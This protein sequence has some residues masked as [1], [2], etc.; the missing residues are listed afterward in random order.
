MVKVNTRA[1]FLVLGESLQSPISKDDVNWV[2]CRCPLSGWGCS[3][4]FL[5]CRMFLSHKGIFFNF[6]SA[7]NFSPL[8]ALIPAPWTPSWRS[9]KSASP[10]PLY[11]HSFSLVLLF[12]YDLLKI[13]STFHLPCVVFVLFYFFILPCP[14]NSPQ[15]GR[16]QV[17]PVHS[18]SFRFYHSSWEIV[19]DQSINIVE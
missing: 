18:C 5:V 16:D 9:S 13:I 3:H 15:E 7:Y 11:N 4:L 14:W 10:A 19:V 1:L 8:R 12:I 2:F 17:Y 6:K